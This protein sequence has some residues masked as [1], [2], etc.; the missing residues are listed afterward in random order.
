VGAFRERV[1]RSPD[2]I[3]YRDYDRAEGGWRDHTWRTIFER[4]A[5]FRAAL[6]RENITAGDC[7]AILLPN[8]LGLS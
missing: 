3:A 4:V 8:R 5:R 1:R 6:A 7:V 2:A